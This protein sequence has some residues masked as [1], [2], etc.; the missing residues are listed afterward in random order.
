MEKHNLYF[1]CKQNIHKPNILRRVFLIKHHLLYNPMNI[2][3]INPKFY[4]YDE[5][6]LSPYTY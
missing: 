5:T 2:Q 3:N 1:Q 4:R 6:S